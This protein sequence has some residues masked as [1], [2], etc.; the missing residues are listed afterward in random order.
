VFGCNKDYSLCCVAF[1]F[2]FDSHVPGVS[3]SICLVA[4]LA[5]KCVHS[6]GDCVTLIS[7]NRL[8]INLLL[9]LFAEIFSL[10]HDC[11]KLPKRTCAFSV[12]HT[13]G[14]TNT[15]RNKQMQPSLKIFKILSVQLNLN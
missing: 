4:T 2:M 5:S 13:V 9:R 15:Y 6:C 10:T 14:S 1:N 3:P 12:Y 11:S 7:V 8:Q